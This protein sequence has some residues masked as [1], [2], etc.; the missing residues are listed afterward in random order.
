MMIVGKEGMELFQI[1]PKLLAPPG[2]KRL[3][4]MLG[5]HRKRVAKRF[6]AS[7]CPV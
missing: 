6:A 1:E 5:L 7:K 2:F 3:P 4:G